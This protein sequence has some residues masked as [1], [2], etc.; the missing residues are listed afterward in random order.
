MTST[1]HYQQRILVEPFRREPGATSVPAKIQIRFLFKF[2]FEW[3]DTLLKRLSYTVL[4][5][6][7]SVLLQVF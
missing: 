3:F 1:V 2:S 7:F 6:E 4:E 5:P